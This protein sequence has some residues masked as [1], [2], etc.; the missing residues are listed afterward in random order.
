MNIQG[1]KIILR[2]LDIRDAQFLYEL[3]ND[4][5]TEKMLGGSSLPISLE[6]QKNWIVSQA[7]RDDVVRC[8]VA[9][10]E[11]M[12]EG[13]GTVIL[14]DIDRKNGVAQVHIKMK[15][16]NG[17]RKGFGSD[18][19]RTIVRY[20]FMEMRLNCIY[21]E[22]LSYN[23]PSQRLFEKCGFKRDGCLRSRIYKNGEFVDVI[24][25]SILKKQFE[26]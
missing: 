6:Q 15:I 8:V 21:A 3:I 2:A 22:V 25:Y 17:R 23:Q 9:V 5:E 10:K 20:A 1:E 4:P 19:L 14:S 18:A 26:G 7:G 12:E 13:L 11:N 24:S 16:S